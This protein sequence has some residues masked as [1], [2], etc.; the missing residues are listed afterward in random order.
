MPK[1]IFDEVYNEFNKKVKSECMKSVADEVNTPF[2]SIWALIDIR[3]DCWE[4]TSLHDRSMIE[5]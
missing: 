4:Y 3:P 2:L 5:I 1:L